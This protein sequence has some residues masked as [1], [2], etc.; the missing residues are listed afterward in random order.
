MLSLLVPTT[1]DTGFGVGFGSFSVVIVFVTFVPEVIIDEE[2]FLTGIVFFKS[3]LVFAALPDPGNELFG[4]STS[5]LG[6][7]RT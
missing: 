4:S 3:L 5:P 1:V 6:A 2:V 7:V